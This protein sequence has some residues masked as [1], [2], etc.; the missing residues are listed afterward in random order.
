M[1]NEISVSRIISAIFGNKVAVRENLFYDTLKGTV[2][3]ADDDLVNKRYVD[4]S[5]GGIPPSPTVIV[6]GVTRTP[7]VIAYSATSSPA[8]TLLRT[9]DN[10]YDNNTTIIYDGA[11]FTILGVDDG[12]GKF[13]DGYK[14]SIKP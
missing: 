6:A 14:F 13:A 12:T 11:N 8:Y 10:S 1:K 4:S 3:F 2:D 9:S 7:L 5:T